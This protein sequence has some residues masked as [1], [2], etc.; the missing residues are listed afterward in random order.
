MIK[1]ST[2]KPCLP[3]GRF[4]A[5]KQFR[6]K[7]RQVLFN[8]DFQKI[9]SSF[10]KWNKIALITAVWISACL[11]GL[12]ILAFYAKTFFNGNMHLW[13]RIVIGLYDE[14]KPTA[15][16]GLVLHF[17][18]GGIILVLGSIQLIKKIRL[19]YPALHRWLGRIYITAAFLAGIGGLIYIVF[20]GT[21][22]GGVM[23][24]GF[25]IYGILMLI[26]SFQAFRYARARDFSLHRQW[27][28]RL[29][30]LAIAS[31]LYRMYYGFW[32]LLIGYGHNPH[33]TGP[34][35]MIMSFF[36]YL[37]NL[38]IVEILIRLE[39]NP[40]NPERSGRDESPAQEN[41][42]LIKFLGGSVFLIATLFLAVGSFYFTKFYWGPAIL[43]WFH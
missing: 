3:I 13:N 4:V 33:F 31:W 39:K 29:Y 8:I 26:T 9:S 11:F 2:S 19:R 22:G 25:S 5:S 6:L 18:T 41:K 36:F 38:L 30:S 40:D 12:Y 7:P 34:F 27:A 14:A 32:L 10:F 35:D 43:S 21:V 24:V 15:T 20:K 28:L 1:K 17:V 42:P 37:P 23:N 16:A